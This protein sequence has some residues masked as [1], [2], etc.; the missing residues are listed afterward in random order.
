MSYSQEMKHRFIAMRAEGF[1]FHKIS[2][3]LGDLAAHADQVV[4]AFQGP[5]RRP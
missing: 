4:G 1:S 2:N 5:N 3:I